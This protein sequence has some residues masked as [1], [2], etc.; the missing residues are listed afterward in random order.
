M[1]KASRLGGTL[2][3]FGSIFGSDGVLPSSVVRTTPKIPRY[4]RSKYKPH[5]GKQECARRVRQMRRRIGKHIPDLVEPIRLPEI[6]KSPIP[7][8]P[9]SRECPSC[10]KRSDK[11]M[12]HYNGHKHAIK[13]VHC[14][15]EWKGRIL[16]NEVPTGA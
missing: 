6:A 16:A 5:Q 14:G 2:G 7:F 11:Q 12:G 3:L 4:A 10:K 8:T 13:C 9:V 1:M 15:H